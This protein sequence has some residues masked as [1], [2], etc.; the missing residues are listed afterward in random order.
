[1][2]AARYTNMQAITTVARLLQVI[3]ST[4]YT[5]SPI[6]S[7]S[8][9]PTVSASPVSSFSVTSFTSYTPIQTFNMSG[10]YSATVSGSASTSYSPM[11]SPS[12]I[13]PIT[14]PSVSN[15]P[16]AP[17]SSPFYVLTPEQ[18]AY[19]LVPCISFAVI[20]CWCNINLWSRVDE[21]DHQ[22]KT[23]QSLRIQNNPMNHNSV[24]NI[25]P[26]LPNSSGNKAAFSHV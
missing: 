13:S 2:P 18:W 16:R 8:P 3:N 12:F 26:A 23:Y 9:A 19:I 15:S 25:I 6:G 21:L 10:Y 14:V 22:L 24:R 5:A 20:T 4:N 7:Y 1:M 17:S 11:P